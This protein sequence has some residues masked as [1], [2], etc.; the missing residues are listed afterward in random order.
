MLFY[1]SCEEKGE[2]SII[3]EQ[4]LTAIHEMVEIKDRYTRGHSK[5]VAEYARR[6]AERL[7]KSKEEQEEIYRAGLLHDVGKIRVPSEIINKPDKLTEEEF[8]IL[9]QHPETGYYILRSISEK[10]E[11]TL[12][13]KYHHERYDGTGYPSGLAGENIPEIAR[14]LCVADSYDAMASN[15]SYRKA[16]PQETVR[17]EIK[18]GRGTQFDP[19]I[20]DVMLKLMEEDTEYRMRENTSKEKD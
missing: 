19:G 5:R 8:I 14:I 11:I 10:K 13:A 1:E 16:L 20:A 7:G 12:A 18:K 3:Q 6:I 4:K 9:K 15:R 2:V 17:E